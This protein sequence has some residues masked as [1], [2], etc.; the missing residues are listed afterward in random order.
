MERREG[1]NRA[2]GSL[3]NRAGHWLTDRRRFLTGAG[4]YGALLMGAAYVPG[5]SALE[6]V[7]AQAGAQGAD[8]VPVEQQKGAVRIMGVVQRRPGLTRTE[9]PFADSP[10]IVPAYYA[11][12]YRQLT[13]KAPGRELASVQNVVTDCAF[14]GDRSLPPGPENLHIVQAPEPMPCTMLSNRDMVSE[15]SF[16]SVVVEGREGG[17]GWAPNLPRWAEPGTELNLAVQQVLAHG[18]RPSPIAGGHKAMYFLKM[19]RSVAAAQV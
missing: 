15:V 19:S 9:A 3:L 10:H 18:T 1:V 11:L 14:G 4:K 8:E 2:A 12:V 5:R 7:Y 16:E 17:K 6:T 13:K